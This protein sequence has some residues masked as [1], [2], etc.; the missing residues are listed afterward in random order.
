[1]NEVRRQVPCHNSE[2]AKHRRQ[3]RDALAFDKLLF[4][5]FFLISVS[6]QMP[7]ESLR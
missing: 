1:M 4:V 5:P 7:F 2:S 3:E 6:V